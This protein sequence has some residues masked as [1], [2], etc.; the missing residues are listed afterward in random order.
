VLTTP[1]SSR[2]QHHPLRVFHTA[3]TLGHLRL[4]PQTSERLPI[5]ELPDE[6]PYCVQRLLPEN[7]HSPELLQHAFRQVSLGRSVALI[8]VPHPLAALNYLFDRLPDDQRRELSFSLGLK[9][10][11]RRPARVYLLSRANPALRAQ[12]NL[13]GIECVSATPAVDPCTPVQLSTA[14]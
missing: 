7:G 11:V 13:M 8:G 1:Q 9:V 2:Y 5:V 3:S 10:T 14:R 6:V 4:L 12:L